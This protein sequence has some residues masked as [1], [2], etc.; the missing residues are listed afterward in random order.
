[1]IGKQSET[2]TTQD[3]EKVN[4]NNE[5]SHYL[6]CRYVSASEAC[7]HI[8]EFPIHFRKPVVQHLYFH[9]EDQQEV[10][11]RENE[12]LPSVLRRTDPDGTMF[13]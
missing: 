3:K 12:T 7:W 13:I 11:Y 10:Q 4:D 6:A 8:F 2:T 1:M 9:L 5:V